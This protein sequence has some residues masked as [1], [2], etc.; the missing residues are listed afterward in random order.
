MRLQG[1]TIVLTGTFSFLSRKEVADGLQDEGATVGESVTAKTDLVISGE[2]GGSTLKAA[3]EKGIPILNKDD[4]GRLLAGEHL[5]DV[6]KSYQIRSIP[7]LD[8]MARLRELLSQEPHEAVWRAVLALIDEC[9]VDERELAI[10]YAQEHLTSWKDE[11]RHL[12]FDKIDEGDCASRSWSLVRSITLCELDYLVDNP[13]LFGHITEILLDNPSL[14]DASCENL[15]WLEVFPHLTSFGLS[16][17]H[18]SVSCI[19]GLLKLPELSKVSI[20]SYTNIAD[21]TVLSRIPHLRE[22]KLDDSHN[23]SIQPLKL[24]SATR[25]ATCDPSASG[26]NPTWLDVTHM[27]QLE[28]YEYIYPVD[29][30]IEC[31]VED[32]DSEDEEERLDSTGLGELLTHLATMCSMPAVSLLRVKVENPSYRK[33]L[34]EKLS[35]TVTIQ[36]LRWTPIGDMVVARSKLSGQ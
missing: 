16:G 18:S 23:E 4:L 1:I 12:H 28:V 13:L 14:R 7:E 9:R 36:Y 31:Y 19:A 24:A 33:V 30:I 27:E 15:D 35:A 34:E 29:D 17:G 32:E 20:V 10:Q 5:E 26:S 21:Y 25:L 11:N 8:D 3:K 2:G 22:L 6:L